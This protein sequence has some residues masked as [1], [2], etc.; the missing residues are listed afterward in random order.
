MPGEQAW[1][2]GLDGSVHWSTSRGEGRVSCPQ[3][4]CAC[5]S[6]CLEGASVSSGP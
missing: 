5:C 6:L 2:L 3:G 4:L 1:G